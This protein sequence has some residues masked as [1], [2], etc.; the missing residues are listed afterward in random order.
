VLSVD[1]FLTRILAEVRTRALPDPA[2]TPDAS[3]T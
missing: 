3:S 2:S 1:D